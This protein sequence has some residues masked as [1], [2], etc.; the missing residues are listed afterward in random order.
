MAQLTGFGYQ[1]GNSVIHQLDP[2]T[3]LF[4]FIILNLSV[5]TS[6]GAGLAIHVCF[7]L[8]CAAVIRIPPG[9]LIRETRFLFLFLGFLI[10][11]RSLTTPDTIKF[12]LGPVDVTRRGV[13][14]GV[15]LS[16]RII[17]IVFWALLFTRTTRPLEIKATIQWFLRPVPLIPEKRV[18]MMISLMIRF[19]PA[20]LEQSAEIDEAL[21]TR[22]IQHRKNPFYRIRV[23]LTPFTRRVFT[24]ADHLA[25]A[26]ISRCYSEER[27]EPVFTAKKKDGL[28]L[29]LTI[30]ASILIIQI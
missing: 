10:V 3:K 15:L 28:F 19:I 1:A 11:I 4:G 18:A 21:K 27:T 7:L 29:A 26:M 30:V 14:E 24:S 23:F 9:Q 6:S 17:T 8:L 20:I 13:M 25:D 22:C 5:A 12:T 2:R 16:W